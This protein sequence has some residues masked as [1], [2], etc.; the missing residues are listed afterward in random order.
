MFEDWKEVLSR[1]YDLAMEEET[2]T[3]DRDWWTWLFLEVF[4][5]LLIWIIGAWKTLQEQI[6][7]SHKKHYFASRSFVSIKCIF[8]C[9]LSLIFDATEPPLNQERKKVAVITGGNR[10]I[11]FEAVRV[12]LKM[13]YR[14]IIGKFEIFEDFL[15]NMSKSSNFFLGCRDVAGCKEKI[16]KLRIKN[17]LSKC[18]VKELD[19]S[20]LDSV[21]KFADW[22]NG[23][24]WPIDVLINNG[25]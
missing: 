3:P 25:N 18:Q 20:K 17:E 22:V 7:T 4:Y 2:V 19:L 13:D 23:H 10:G 21:E 11:G 8:R 12:L 1:N 24:E 5:K 15:E 9:I 16:K 6:L 14:I